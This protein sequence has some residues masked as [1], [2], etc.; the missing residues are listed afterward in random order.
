MPHSL[1]LPAL[2]CTCCSYFLS[3]PRPAAPRRAL[4]TNNS[5]EAYKM[6][7][8]FFLWSIVILITYGVSILLLRASIKPVGAGRTPPRLGCSRR[9]CRHHC[10]RNSRC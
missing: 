8:A 10:R 7:A 4:Q 3:P 1:S 5:L 2:P 6:L 9:R